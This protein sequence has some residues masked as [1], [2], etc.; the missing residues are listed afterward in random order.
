MTDAL[1][2]GSDAF[3][4]PDLAIQQRIRERKRKAAADLLKET[5]E[6]KNGHMLEGFGHQAPVFVSNT[7]NNQLPFLRS[8]V[9]GAM[10]AGIDKEE[11]DEATQL[12]SVRQEL[13]RRM[14]KDPTDQAALTRWGAQ[15]SQV[16]GMAPLG[17]AAFKEG[18]NYRKPEKA[19]APPAGY[20]WNENG[21]LSP[22]AG[23]PADKK[24]NPPSGFNWNEDGTLSFVPGGPGDPRYKQSIH[25]TTGN[26]GAMPKPPSGYKW[27]GE[28]LEPIPGGPAD[29]SRTKALT[30]KQLETQRGY[31]DLEKSL[32]N[33]DQ[34]LRTYDPQGKT[35]A[36]PTER[37]AIESAYTD[38]MMKIKTLYELGAPQAGDLKLLEQSLSNP[39]SLGGTIKGIVT[40]RDP[41]LAKNKEIR[42]LLGNSQASFDEQMGVTTPRQPAPAAPAREAS[43][44]IGKPKSIRSDAEYNALPSGSTYIAP[45]GQ[46]RRKK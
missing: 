36:S 7:H 28:E 24:R 23:G 41:F 27:N 37:A 4:V 10:N 30:P 12:N 33:Y 8:A 38:L 9:A 1:Y 11:Q 35:A 16:P 25:I 6:F 40:G 14:P 19:T 22:I 34:M 46:V 29:P 45:D 2:P 20:A 32:N 3:V 31:I 44:S 18:I 13:L 43:G 26:R 17:A 15:A 5:A 42:K 39:T 21:S